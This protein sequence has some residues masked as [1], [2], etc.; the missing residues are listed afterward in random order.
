[1]FQ[2]SE[3]INLVLA[4]ISVSFLVGFRTA[5]LPFPPFFL[6]AYGCLM[7]SYLATVVEGVVLKSVFNFIEH[8]GVALSGILFAVGI[9]RLSRAA[10]PDRQQESDDGRSCHH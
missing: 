5:K 8:L 2:E 3:L 6:A 9:L 4:L 1:M 7:A 10:T